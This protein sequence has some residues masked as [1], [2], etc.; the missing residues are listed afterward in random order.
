MT[1]PKRALELL[2]KQLCLYTNKAE[3]I[4]VPKI[5]DDEAKKKM[6]GPSLV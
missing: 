2:Y 5:R 3:N 1:T 4:L 6:N